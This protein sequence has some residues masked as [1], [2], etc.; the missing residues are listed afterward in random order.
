VYLD[1]VLLLGSLAAT[2]ARR[3]LVVRRGA[4]VG[5]RAWFTGLGYGARLLSP[6]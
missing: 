3:A 2:R 5:E 6:C 1:T 4:G